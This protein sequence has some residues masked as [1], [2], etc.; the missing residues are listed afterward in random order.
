MHLLTPPAS[1]L[2]HER[3]TTSLLEE[4]LEPTTRM[5]SEW[6]PSSLSARRVVRVVPVIEAGAKLCFVI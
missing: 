1:I 2:E 5:M 6:V 4:L 3:S